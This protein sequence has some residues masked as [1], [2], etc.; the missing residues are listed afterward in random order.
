M[1]IVEATKEILDLKACNTLNVDISAMSL[2]ATLRKY[3]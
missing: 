2:L 3:C 1:D